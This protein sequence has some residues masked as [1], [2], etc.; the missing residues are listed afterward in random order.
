MPGAP[1]VASLL[2]LVRPGAPS[3]FLLLVVGEIT[4]EIAG[5]HCSSRLDHPQRRGDHSSDE[6]P[7]R[8]EV[9]HGCQN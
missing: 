5:P 7:F 4:G 8:E 1:I 3:S 6:P 2:L 9:G